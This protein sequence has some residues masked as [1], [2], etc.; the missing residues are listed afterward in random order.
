MF[1]RKTT[2]EPEPLKDGGKGHPTPTRKEAEADARARAKASATGV[3]PRKSGRKQR[4]ASSRVAREGWKQGDER[5][6]PERDRGPVRRF[7]RDTVDSRLN[8][9]ELLLPLLVLIL[10]LGMFHLD[11]VA[12][13]LWS[14]TILLVG[15]D[16]AWLMFKARREVRRRFPDKSLRGTS[17]YVAFRAIQLR[18]TRIPK[19]QVKLGAKLGDD[20]R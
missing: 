10:V 9:A 8:V 4:I 2:Q 20:Y 15:L 17:T 12:N 6:L 13:A 1:R 19:P 14:T 16:T 11:R 18:P 5:Y 3:D 7:L